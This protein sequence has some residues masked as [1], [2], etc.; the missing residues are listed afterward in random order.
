MLISDPGFAASWRDGDRTAV[1]DDIGC[2]LRGLDRD[3]N[4]SESAR[5]WVMDADRR[6]HPASDVVFV[7]SDRLETPMAGHV[8][9]FADRGAAERAAAATGGELAIDFAH[10]RVLARERAAREGGHD[11]PSG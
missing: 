4:A 3:P 8:Q 5:V 7:V 1:F 6:W 11:A 9:A 2:L 10:L